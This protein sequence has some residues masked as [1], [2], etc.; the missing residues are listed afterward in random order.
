M[1]MLASPGIGMTGISPSLPLWLCLMACAAPQALTLQVCMVEAKPTVMAMLTGKK[2]GW[3]VPAILAATL[4]SVP[5]SLAVT[6]GS[7]RDPA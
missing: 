4:G 2:S 6:D 1:A 7:C 5:A 3:T